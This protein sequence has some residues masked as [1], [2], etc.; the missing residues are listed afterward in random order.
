MANS[1]ES[2]QSRGRSD[3]QDKLKEGTDSIARIGDEFQEVKDQLQDIPGGLDD[4][5][6][7]MIRQAEA[8]GR[9]E[10]MRDIDAVKSS[11]IDTAK[12]EAD[13][14]GGDVQTKL[15]DNTAARGTLDS[16]SSKYGRDAVSKAK[17]AIDA[18]SKMGE[19]ILKMLDTAVKEAEQNVQDVINQL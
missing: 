16:I 14:I 5:L 3:V 11:V 15:S 17:S 8:D 2:F 9:S 6:L 19:D 4:D 7:D 18:N 13:S 12:R 10:A 1:M